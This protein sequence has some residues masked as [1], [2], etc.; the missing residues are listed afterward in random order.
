MRTF[1]LL[2]VT[3]N[4]LKNLLKYKVSFVVYERF[5]NPA[6]IIDVVIMFYLFS[7]LNN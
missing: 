7:F 2:R 5:N 4:S 1:S 6:F 3:F